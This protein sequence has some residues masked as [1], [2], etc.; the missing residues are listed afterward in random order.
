MQLHVSHRMIC[1]IGS[2]FDRTA[3]AASRVQEIVDE[4]EKVPE[5]EVATEEL[6]VRLR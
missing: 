4:L 2:G 3:I 1:K 5:S 6:L